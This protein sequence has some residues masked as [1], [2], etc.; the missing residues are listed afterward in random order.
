MTT[1]FAD[2]AGVIAAGRCRH[3]PGAKAWMIARAKGFRK[4]NL[5]RYGLTKLGVLAGGLA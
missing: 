5:R 3:A 4:R 2:A 1:R